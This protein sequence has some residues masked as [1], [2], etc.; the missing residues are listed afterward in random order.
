VRTMWASTGGSDSIQSAT[1][2]LAMEANVFRLLQRNGAS[3]QRRLHIASASTKDIFLVA[4]AGYEPKRVQMAEGILR[5][6]CPRC[7]TRL[8]PLKV[9]G[10]RSWWAAA[11][12]WRL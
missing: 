9:S 1:R 5:S 7:A 2:Y 12:S 10:L 8:K 6:K 11:T 4:A 3:S